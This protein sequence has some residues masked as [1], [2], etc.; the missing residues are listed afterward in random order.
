M[1]WMRRRTLWWPEWPAVLGGFATLA[2][3]FRL[4]APF[5]Y[6]I[7][8]P[9]D[10]EAGADWTVVEGWIPDYA[11]SGLVRR[12]ALSTAPVLTTGGPLER[13]AYLAGYGTYAELAR[14]TLAAAGVATDRVAAVPAPSA[15]RDRTFASAV[16]LRRHFQA[17]GVASGTVVLVTQDVH[18]RRS[19][20]L[21]R[22]AL[23]PAFKV[24][25]RPY[26]SPIYGRGDW[27][28]SSEGVRAVVG[29]WL[30]WLHTL[31]APPSARIEEAAGQPGP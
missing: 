19:R 15:R 21:F 12:L 14:A 24:Q 8:A 11:V 26:P 30:A 16:A 10:E 20:A 22:R 7:L 17:I 3:L 28:R 13:G 27:W 9:T 5:A 1:R 18:A 31:V 4:S 25:A 6:D 23:G 29:E 2:V